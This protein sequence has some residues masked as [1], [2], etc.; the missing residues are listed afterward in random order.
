MNLIQTIYCSQYYE[1]K[2]S[3]RDYT[4]G[5]TNGTVLVAAILLLIIIAVIVPYCVYVP[6]NGIDRMFRG[7][8][9]SGRAMG[10]IL[11]LGGLALLYGIL[12]FTAGSKSSYDRMIQQW[13]NMSDDELKATVKKAMKIFFVA[14][15]LFLIAMIAAFAA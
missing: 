10:K 6:G 13:E 14:F 11:G 12:N 8:G 1:L 3:G 7:T 5:R 15:G 9:M 2:K 4:K